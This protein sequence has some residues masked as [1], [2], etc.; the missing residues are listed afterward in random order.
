MTEQASILYG[1]SIVGE[2]DTKKWEEGILSTTTSSTGSPY[3][4]AIDMAKKE[5]KKQGNCLKLQEI[6]WEIT[7]RC[8]NNCD[9]C[10]SKEGRSQKIDDKIIRDIA[11]AI[12]K[13]PP[14][15]IDISGG[16]PLLVS[17]D[18][19]K[20]VVGLL[21]SV[22]VQVKM[23]INP[24]S[25]TRGLVDIKG[26][27]DILK[28]YD[29]IGVSINSDAELEVY[30]SRA[31]LSGMEGFANI[32]IISNFNKNNIFTYDDIESAVKFKN[33]GW[34]IQFTMYKNE[35]S[36]D[37]LYRNDN[38]VKHLFEKI[39][40]S[41][42]NGVKIIPADNMNS[43]LCGAGTRSIGILSN[44]DVV[45]C[46]SMQSWVKDIKEVVQGNL[47]NDKDGKNGNGGHVYH[48]FTSLE[49]IWKSGFKKYRFE[50]FKCC[51]DHCGNREITN[52]CVIPYPYVSA[53]GV[54]P[55]LNP[56]DR[57]KAVMYG[58]IPDV[59]AY[60]VTPW[61][62]CKPGNEINEFGLLKSSSEEEDAK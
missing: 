10:G 42:S 20:L 6:I 26:L 31:C 13:Y 37:A 23:L 36:P 47:V 2:N 5:K 15:A 34:Q 45:P 29:W 43:G 53:Y 56:D 4:V 61:R 48:K 12:S 54:M 16:D 57:M 41:I 32:T 14:E 17:Y 40:K 28:L 55:P 39:N 3:Y 24:M 27:I 35:H 49:E 18:T 1:I 8:E 50:C 59:M 22:G 25:F 7:G 19:H 21:K 60:M 46:L 38:A 62:P 11:I 52:V 44:G 33:C 30:K 51:K 58:V 9:Y